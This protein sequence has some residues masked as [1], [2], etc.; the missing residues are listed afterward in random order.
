MQLAICLFNHEWWVV[1]TLSTNG[2][3]PDWC[4]T[5]FVT[6]PQRFFA[7][8]RKKRGAPADRGST[9]KNDHWN[10]GT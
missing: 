6:Y 2:S 7:G 8:T 1:Q 10:R 9:E 4:K 5:I 3:I